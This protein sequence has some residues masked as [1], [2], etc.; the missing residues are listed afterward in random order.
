MK[1]NKQQMIFVGVAGVIG[2]VL[3]LMPSSKTPPKPKVEKTTT[4]LLA[5]TRKQLV[6]LMNSQEVKKSTLKHLQ[7]SDR[8]PFISSTDG[9]TQ[10]YQGLILQGVFGGSDNPSVIINNK[11]FGVGEKIDDKIVSDIKGDYVVLV[12]ATGK[13]TMISMNAT[14][15][16]H[17]QGVDDN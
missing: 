10:T 1:L 6:V 8:N 16:T 5:G 9:S 7:Y 17:V 4:E 12:D 3:F 14:F 15:P 13:Q 2:A 11:V